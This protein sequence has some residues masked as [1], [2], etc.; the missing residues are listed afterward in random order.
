MLAVVVGLGLY[1]L[2]GLKHLDAS[3]TALYENGAK[4]LATAGEYRAL[5]VR[6]FLNLAQGITHPTA[7]GREENL[8]KVPTRLLEAE[9]MLEMLKGQ[10]QSPKAKELVA[11]S[12]PLFQRLQQ[13]MH[14]V[15]DLGRKGDS[16]NALK[17]L[18]GD[19]DKLRRE[20]GEVNDKLVTQVEEDAKTRAE[21]NSLQAHSLVAT[22]TWIIAISAL[23]A[24]LV[25][26]ILYRNT[27]R[28]IDR[29]STEYQRVGTGIL[30]G[31][32]STR[33]D[34][35]SVPAEFGGL[36]DNLNHILEA[37]VTP[38][39]MAA[40]YVD[41]IAKGD[42]PAALTES[43][44]GDFNTIKDN[45]NLL[46]ESTNLVTQAL[47]GIAGGDLS[48]EVRERSP[49]DDLM[50]ALKQLLSSMD[51]VTKVAKD[52][53]G[54]DLR[55]EIRARSERDELMKA[56]A[57]MVA[58]LSDV[59]TEVKI[60]ADHV[61]SGAQQMSASSEQLSQGATEQASSIEE[62]SSSMEQ[63]G[64]NVRQNADN[65]T[66]TEV[67]ARKAA[68]DAKEG[69]QAVGQTVEA[70]KQIAGRITIIEE[71]ARQTNLLALNA[72][73]EAAR[74][75]EHGKGFAV[76][77]SEVRKLA[78][79]SQKAAG[80]ITALSTSSVDVAEKAGQ[81]FERILPDVQRTAQ[82]VQEITSASREQDT[83][84]GQING[85]LQQLDH[86]IQGNAAASEEMSATSEELSRQAVQLQEAI[87]F[88]KL[89]GHEVSRA[90]AAAAPPAIKRVARPPLSKGMR[91]PMTMTAPAGR[92]SSPPAKPANG[93]TLKLDADAEDGQFEE[94]SDKGARP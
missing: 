24:V 74:A 56:L 14:T 45:L 38:L 82:L 48:I 73:I 22:S 57:S 78:E 29:V 34:A 94:F 21:G 8:A 33:A 1:F 77:A 41:R 3:D 87:S 35:R 66:Q 16:E 67:I 47:Q 85:A 81:I 11:Q 50:H 28:A 75:G 43:Y 23:F 63:M 42:I 54:G 49:K 65:S 39:T 55:I 80:E 64:A 62:V 53:A 36:V 4:P 86:V 5:V 76:V 90:S 93:I 70:M 83:G 18:F 6:S 88:F 89:S 44:R 7:A 10:I 9:K 19:V 71:I 59:V 32:L 26:I 51:D 91:P 31:E 68:T 2:T 25:G 52:I 79:R 17:L 37:I 12:A 58:R 72:A 30:A 61:A 15:V 40:N 46:I 20:Q 60:A 84:A 92:K 13:G 27:T 69:G